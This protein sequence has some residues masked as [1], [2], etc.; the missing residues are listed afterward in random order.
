MTE[1]EW[2]TRIDWLIIWDDDTRV[3]ALKTEL[4]GRVEPDQ[5]GQALAA[6][7]EQTGMGGGTAMWLRRLLRAQAPGWVG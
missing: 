2:Q 4:A 6:L 5:P 7:R 1:T 3:L